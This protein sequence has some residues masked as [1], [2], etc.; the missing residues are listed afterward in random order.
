[1]L[2]LQPDQRAQSVL[3]N[4]SSGLAVGGP[5]V[6]PFE[7]VLSS[8][9]EDHVAD[10]VEAPGLPCQPLSSAGSRAG[11]GFV[12]ARGARIPNR[13]QMTLS[14]NTGEEQQNTVCV[15]RS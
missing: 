6:I 5:E 14:P 9:A 4:R 11:I 1:M 12:A 8:G 10:N 13:G 7:A 15:A 3:E 2:Q